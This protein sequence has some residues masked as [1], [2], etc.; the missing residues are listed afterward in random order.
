MRAAGL[1]EVPRPA[2]VAPRALRAGDRAGRPLAQVRVPVADAGKVVVG[3]GAITLEGYGRVYLVHGSTDR[4]IVID[5]FL[6]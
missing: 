6:R 5:E 1:R 4:I 3:W 2:A